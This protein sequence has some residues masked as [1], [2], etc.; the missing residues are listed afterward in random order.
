MAIKAAD[1]ITI[2]DITDAYSVILTSEAFTFVGGTGGAAGFAAA[3]LASGGRPGGRQ[4]GAGDPAG[5]RSRGSAGGSPGRPGGRPAGNSGS[6]PRVRQP[7]PVPDPRRRGE[8]SEQE[9]ENI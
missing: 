6:I 7:Q 8:L 5:H 2:T 3:G 4:F 1:Q 9:A